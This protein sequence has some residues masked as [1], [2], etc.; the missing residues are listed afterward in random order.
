MYDTIAS[1]EVIEKT[2]QNLAPRRFEGIVAANKAEAL[3]K[4]KELIPKGASVMNGSSRTL[5]EI[6]FIDYLKA[7]EHGWDN[8]HAQVLAETDPEKRAQL[9]KSGILSDYYLGSVHALTQEGEMVIASNTGSQLPHIAFTS[10]NL[11]FV[12][13]AQK[14]V[15]DLKS[16]FERLENYVVGLEDE[17]LLQV[18]G[19]HT[20]RSKT[21]IFHKES[22]QSTRN[23]KVIIVKEK[24]GF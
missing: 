14:I 5:E 17:R 15:A 1:D 20:T 9:R 13:G 18:Y 24:L 11:I 16:A 22:P 4:I 3:D 19:V 8:L 23:V 2:I 12:V 7:G 21:L 10:P 6:G